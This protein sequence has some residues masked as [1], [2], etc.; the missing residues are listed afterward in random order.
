MVGKINLKQSKTIKT[1]RYED[2]ILKTEY[3]IKDI[4]EFL[5]IDWE[6]EICNFSG[7]PLDFLKSKKLPENHQPPSSVSVDQFPKPE[8]GF[9]KTN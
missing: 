9:G 2:L 1:I 4:C 5:E 3:T 8:L 7:Q 6:P